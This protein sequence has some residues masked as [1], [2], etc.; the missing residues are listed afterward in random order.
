MRSK[1]YYTEQMEMDGKNVGIKVKL[2][3]TGMYL[4]TKNKRDRIFTNVEFAKSIAY[5]NGCNSG[6]DFDLVLYVY[7]NEIYYE[8]IQTIN[9]YLEFFGV[10][11]HHNLIRYMIRQS[12]CR[13]YNNFGY[14]VFDQGDVIR[15]SKTA[16][17]KRNKILK[18]IIQHSIENLNDK[19]HVIE[20]I[21]IWDSGISLKFIHTTAK[22]DVM[23]NSQ[24]MDI[25]QWRKNI[26]TDEIEYK[27]C[28]P[29]IKTMDKYTTFYT[30]ISKELYEPVKTDKSNAK[31]PEN[32]RD[33]LIEDLVAN[34]KI[35]NK[36]TQKNC[37]E[38]PQFKSVYYKVAQKVLSN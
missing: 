9:E 31:L 10:D 6:R 20:D 2:K 36:N 8:Y 33:L 11:E 15:T 30:Y 32:F 26:E 12:Q 19:Y 16:G 4:Q 37:R 28:F 23:T 34:W 24:M 27:H 5:I 22:L 35:Y 18:S 7:G 3:S 17:E 38:T 29:F 21:M 13:E 1:E 14:I 25:N